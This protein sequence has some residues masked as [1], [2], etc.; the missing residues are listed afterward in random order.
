MKYIFKDLIEFFKWK[1]RSKH[2]EI[3]KWAT[4]GGNIYLCL[5]KP[6]QRYM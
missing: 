6:R 1:Y 4:I 2:K 5:R 3:K